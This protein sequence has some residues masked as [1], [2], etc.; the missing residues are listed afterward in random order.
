MSAQDKRLTAALDLVRRMPPVRIEQTLEEL[1]DLVPDLTD[2]LLNTIDQPLQAAKDAQGNTYLNCDYN[3]DGDSYRSPWT[4][5]YDPPIEDGV[6]PPPHLRTLEVAA[7]DLFNSY[8]EMYY[9]G[10]ASSV[11]FWEPDNG[12][13]FAACVLFKKTV[14]AAK[15]GLTAGFW[16]AIHVVEMRPVDKETAHYKLTS[17]IMLSLDTDHSTKS[18][19]G[20]ASLKL[21]GSMTRQ[22]EEKYAGAKDEDHLKN[23]G[24]MLEEMENRMR[25]SL[26]TVYFGRT[27]TTVNKMY[28]MGGASTDKMKAELAQALQKELGK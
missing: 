16:D 1:V 9:E 25:D 13:G 5:T 27:K 15:K 6:M 2:E 8:R 14:E 17:T 7:N 26:Q 23:V 10:G 21:S 19:K 18:T 20:D 11:Y 3:R 12:T 28:R 24:R 22:A 4:N